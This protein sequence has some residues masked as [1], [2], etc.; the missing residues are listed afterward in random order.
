MER[1][2]SELLVDSI[3][4]QVDT[5]FGI[6]GTHTIYLYNEI[7]KA[8]QE[9]RIRH[10]MPR[11]EYGGSIMADYYARLKENVGVFISVPG[12]GFTNAL[13]GLA[14][15]FTESS[16]LVLIS[17]NKEIRYKERRQLHDM[18]Y[19]DAQLNIA[20]E[21]T[22]AT[23][24]ITSPEMVGK[25]MEKAFRLS[26]SDR[27]GPVYIEVPY[28]LLQLK[29]EGEPLR[30]SVS[31]EMVY[32]KEGEVKAASEFIKSCSKPLILA[33]YGSQKAGRELLSFAEELMIPVVTTIRGKGSLP[34]KHP[35]NLGI[36]WDNINLWEF[37]CLIA[38]G[39]SFNDIETFSWKINFPKRILHVDVDEN[40]FNKSV[41]AEVTV[42]GNLKVTLPR[43]AESVGK[44]FA[45]SALKKGKGE[46]LSGRGKITHDLLSRVLDSNLG[47]DRI[48]I[49]DAGTNQVMAFDISVQRP[50]SYFNPL[51]FNAMSSSIP[52]AIGAKI[53]FPER[54]VVAIIGDMG[55]QGCM[56]EL[57]TAKENN[58]NILVVL[59]E[60]GVQHILRLFQMTYH[61]SDFSTNVYPI[62]YS[63]LV[64]SLGIKVISVERAEEMDYKVNTALDE[65]KRG[66]VVLRVKIDPN[67][68]PKRIIMQMK[69]K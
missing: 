16:P 63:A 23:F 4:N 14:Q 13:T 51:V 29:G 5:V 52:A 3:S 43:I 1:S 61:N 35:L 10:V 59:L 65:L 15:A 36:L 47:E 17:A 45:L 31:G 66:P 24:R 67:S 39:T 68:V 33:G 48:I 37:D 26:L 34:E 20:R 42:K 53:A 56:A 40:V 49:A 54:E 27:Q 7:R 32:P 22:K 64:T 44:K 6:P 58:L 50:N 41:I 60:D 19:F 55:F 28:D 9:K 69:F 2:I 8:S 25:V 21:I 38:L 18:Y 62:D 12:P 57:I 30:A 46:D 11:L